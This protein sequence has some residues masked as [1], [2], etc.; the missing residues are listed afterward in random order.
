MKLLSAI[1]IG[2]KIQLAIGVN[3]I[4]AILI[5]EFVITRGLQLSGSTGMLINLAINSAIA[6]LYGYLVSRAITRPLKNAA[7][8]L[9]KLSEEEG[10]LSTCLTVNSN[11]EVGQLCKSFNQFIGKLHG[12]ISHVVDSTEQVVIAAGKMAEITEETTVRV[13]KQQQETDQVAAAMNEMVATVQEVSRTAEEAS[14]ATKNAD[15]EARSGTEA[16]NIAMNGIKTL[17]DKIDETEAVV[18]KLEVE[19]ENIGAVLVVIQSIAEQTNLLA[20]NA[21]IEAARAGEQG[22]GFAVV[23]DEVRTLASRTRESTEEINT[24]INRLQTEVRDVVSAMGKAS[25]QGKDGAEKVDKAIESLNSIASIV[26]TISD[27][28]SL[29]ASAS[30]EQKGTAEEI[31]QNIVNI[32][33][34]S[35][36]TS[37]DASS[38]KQT[39]RELTQ[40]AVSLKQLVGQFKL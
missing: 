6:T 28:N 23:A 31:N 19:S 7:D 13:G 9:K 8:A 2:T 32:S 22:R 15:I 5:G 16:S 17:V 29:I 18:K 40:L 4:L 11:D 14:D 24:M 25:D 34:I 35:Q 26:S 3:V 20:L 39:S 1:N 12:I 27:M 10:D 30:V 33:H 36:Q 21:A 38:T 37:D